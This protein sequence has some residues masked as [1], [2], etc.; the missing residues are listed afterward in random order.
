M[1]V[2]R[3]QKFGKRNGFVVSKVWNGYGIDSKIKTHKNN[4]EEE[5]RGEEKRIEEG[6]TNVPKGETT[7]FIRQILYLFF[8]YFIYN[9]VLFLL[10]LF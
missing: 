10:Y 9:N 3:A 7:L 1:F 5:R 2:S 4:G 6:G 8:S